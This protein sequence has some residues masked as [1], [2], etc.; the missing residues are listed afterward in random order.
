MIAAGA[1]PLDV[2][3]WGDETGRLLRVS[4]PAQNLEVVARGHRVGVHPASDDL[5]RER[6]AGPDSG[7][8]FLPR[9]HDLE[10]RE[11]ERRGGRR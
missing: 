9:R 8:R 7:Q 2:E 3:I 4:V 6:R 5:A 11:A 1:A 10:T